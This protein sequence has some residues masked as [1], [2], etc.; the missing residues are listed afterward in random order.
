MVAC[1]ERAGTFT[2]LVITPTSVN[3][4]LQLVKFIFLQV[5]LG[6]AQGEQGTRVVSESCEI[7][8]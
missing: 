1:V 6:R 3:K 7:G 5:I 2:N 4:S 8:A